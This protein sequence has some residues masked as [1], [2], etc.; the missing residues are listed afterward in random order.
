[1]SQGLVVS[2]RTGRA[3]E[4]PRPDWDQAP[5]RTWRSAYRKDEVAG[6]V[7]VT[8]LGLEGD[9][10]VH[11]DVHGG[12]HMAVLAYAAAHYP[13]WR[14]EPGLE[15]IGPGG[16]A[17]NLTLDGLDERTVCV[18]DVYEA[19]EV[20]L[21]VSQ[22]RKPCAA[23]ARVWDQPAMVQRV[24]ETGRT[25]WF[26]RVTRAGVLAPGATLSRVARPHPDWTVERV[27]RLH[28]SKEADTG[29]LRAIAAC[30]ALSPEWRERFARRAAERG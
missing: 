12:P 19:G 28:L 29:A 7:R 4:Y 25:G 27:F 17:E 13:R 21:E 3:R 8:A 18:G 6:R 5:D 2:I 23:I 14:T 22:P 24:T 20:A 30:D 26:L 15:R 1:M 10:Q 9:E 16:F 11:R